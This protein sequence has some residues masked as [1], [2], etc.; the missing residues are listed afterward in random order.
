MKFNAGC[1]RSYR[2]RQRRSRWIAGF[3]LV[4]LLV[5]IAIIGVL[6]ALLLPAVQAAREAARRMS[7]A[8][9]LRQVGLALHNHHDT[10]GRF[11]LSNYIRRMNPNVAINWG[12]LPQ[13]L[14]Y[15]EQTSLHN[16]FDFELRPHDP[17][18]LEAVQT[19]LD[20]LTCPS[21][22]YG[23]ELGHSETHWTN[24]VK[25]VAET[26]Y[27][28]CVGD[29]RNTTGTGTA[30]ADGLRWYG[31]GDIPP[32][33]VIARYGWSARFRDI[34]D[35]LSNTFALG[36]SV[37]HWSVNVDFPYQ[38]F[39]TTAHPINFKNSVYLEIGNVDWEAR[40]MDGTDPP[41]L[42]WDWAVTFR[43]LHPGGAHFL[44]CDGSVDFFS[45]SIDHITYMAMGSRD[46]GEVSGR[47][48]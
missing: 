28:A 25:E 9:N 12:W 29:Y 1:N 27:A 21:I 48:L 30:G 10:V 3:T 18:N 45:E 38:A 19:P 16:I 33:G 23:N 4:E 22:P 36:E 26:S 13:L 17:R 46:G 47:G 14:P 43:S 44:L 7:C 40:H 32:R 5:V 37:G 24:S 6:V 42:E 31:N 20:V 2:H 39:A 34:T 35:G 11:P 41:E 15:M 8:N